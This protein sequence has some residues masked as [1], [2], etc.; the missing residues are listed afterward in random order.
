VLAK[1]GASL[2]RDSVDA[3]I[4]NNVRNRTGSI[5]NSQADVGGWPVLASAPARRDT[6]NDGIPDTWE[7]RHRLNPADASDANLDRNAN[8]YPDIEDWLNSLVGDA[9]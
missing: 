6:D 5:I 3:R 1:A 7:R 9:T 2:M 8:G 4:V